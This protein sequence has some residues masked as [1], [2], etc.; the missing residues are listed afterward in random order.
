MS[1]SKVESEGIQ[2]LKEIVFKLL[3]REDKNNNM[4]TTLIETLIKEITPALLDSIKE[5]KKPE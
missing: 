5:S 4:M 3:E 2:A 1:E